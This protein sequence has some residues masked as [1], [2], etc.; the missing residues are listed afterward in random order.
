MSTRAILAILVIGAV[1]APPAS[2]GQVTALNTCNA[3]AEMAYQWAVSRDS[4]AS[5]EQMTEE[6]M[7]EAGSPRTGQKAP[8]T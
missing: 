8:R 7:S 1:A 4:G 2:W 5:E 6:L 3:D